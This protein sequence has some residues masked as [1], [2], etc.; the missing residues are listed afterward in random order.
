M[1]WVNAIP[2]PE[3]RFSSFQSMADAMAGR[4]FEEAALWVAQFPE[5][6]G[7]RD[8]A[9]DQVSY[10][11]SKSDHDAAKSWAESLGRSLLNEGPGQPYEP[12]QP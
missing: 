1:E 8:Q 3:L 10:G 4:N 7:I 9:V 5:D 2:D 12:Q 11:W 6:S